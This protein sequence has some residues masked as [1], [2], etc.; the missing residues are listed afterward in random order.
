MNLSMWSPVLAQSLIPGIDEWAEATTKSGAPKWV[1]PRVV[2][3]NPSPR[4]ETTGRL[5]SLLWPLSVQ[6]GPGVPLQRAQEVLAAGE[7]A[8][9]LLSATGWPGG[10]G[11]AGQGGSAGRD[12]YLTQTATRGAAAY[13]DATEPVLE[14]DGARSF[15]VVDARVP[16]KRLPACTAQALAESILFELDPAE[17]A[18]VRQSSAAYLSWL[19]TGDLGC[20][21]EERG[22]AER[23]DLAALGPEESGRG[24]EWLALLGA[25][26]DLNRGTFLRDMWQ[27][28]RQRTWEGTGLRAS[29]DLIEVI[30]AALTDRG[31]QLE[32]VA[33]ELAEQ[34]GLAWL[35][36]ERRAAAPAKPSGSSD[37]TPWTALKWSALPARL[38]MAAEVEPLGSQYALV[39]ID[40]P[41]TPGERLRVWSRGEYGARW[42]LS[43]LALDENLR[44]I[45]RVSAPPRKNPS[46]FAA[47]EM[48]PNTRLVLVTVTNLVDGIPDPDEGAPFQ[49]GNVMLT[50]DRGGVDQP[51]EVDLQ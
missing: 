17:S 1:G 42:A 18:G 28:A 3:P 23:P 46:S 30:A 36:T 15:A 37:A 12:I 21:E 5:D 29:P 38:P 40:Q 49:K 27:F 20:D 32:N 33:A 22:R 45:G 51:L 50:I 2:F 16:E 13:L 41:L 31:E 19:I 10:A 6:L 48:M 4:P 44:V 43:C 8:L 24:A 26:Q 39:S 47:L 9:E 34:Q 7:A 25:R 35:R 11:D 14:L